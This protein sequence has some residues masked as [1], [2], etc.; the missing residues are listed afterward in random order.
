[1][2]HGG[3]KRLETTNTG[4]SITDNLNVAGISTFQNNVILKENSPVL[5]FFDTNA[6]ANEQK[7]D[8]KCG[9]SNDFVIQGINDAGSGGGHLFKMTRV[10]NSNGIQS[11]EAQKSGVTWLTIHN[12][13]LSLIHI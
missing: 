11:F 8:F 4:V 10:S 2:N 13:D 3:T 5:Q 6:D 12:V 9:G 7:W 1:M